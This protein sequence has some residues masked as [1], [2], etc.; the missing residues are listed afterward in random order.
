MAAHGILEHTARRYN[1]FVAYMDL[2]E[3]GPEEPEFAH[4]CRPTG[5]CRYLLIGRHQVISD[6]G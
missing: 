3:Q 4:E 1:E 2:A 6:A 5:D